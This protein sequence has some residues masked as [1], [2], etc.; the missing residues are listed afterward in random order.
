MLWRDT[1]T[2]ESLK[3]ENF[4]LGMATGSEVQSII[5]MVGS[6]A[7]C[8]QIWCCRGSWEFY[9]QICRQQE[10]RETLGLAWVFEILKLT[11]SDALLPTRP[12]LLVLS[13]SACGNHFNSDHHSL[14]LFLSHPL[15]S[16]S[17][18]QAGLNYPS[19]GKSPPST[20]W[21]TTPPQLLVK[22]FVW[23][24]LS[25]SLKT[26]DGWEWG[27]TRLSSGVWMEG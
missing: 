12:H 10:E 5:V 25:D 27:V 1:M 11:L 20:I 2:T 8:R 9:I 21:E 16:P 4:S 14:L 6:M 24:H 19:S 18:A 3:K 23:V 7:E 22:L 15:S 17:I 26:P 13:N